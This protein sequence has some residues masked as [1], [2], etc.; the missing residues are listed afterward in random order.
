MR[1]PG[2]PFADIQFLS[3]LIDKLRVTENIDSARVYATGASSGGIFSYR[4]AC[5]LSGKIAAIGSVAGTDV[6]PPCRPK[7]PVSV[8]EIHELGDP[9]EPYAGTSI[10]PSTPA[11]VAK[12]RSVDQCSSASTTTTTPGVKD[13]SWTKCANGTSV[14][15]I[16]VTGSGHG[17]IRTNGVDATTAIWRFFAAHPKVQASA[18]RPSV[19]FTRVRVV[20]RPRRRVLVSLS[21]GQASVVDA[22]LKRGRR[23]VAKRSERAAKGTFVLV[24]NVP[25]SARPGT[26]KLVVVAKA[27]GSSRQ[28]ARDLHLT[29]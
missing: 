8:I 9:I 5:Y 14:E 15:L 2:T 13:Q 24:L 16:S 21:V 25:V 7:D 18:T 12:W 22:S 1:G 27:S 29:R 6:S 17:W 4:A 10:T 19:R 20:Y 11:V 23:V 28:I 3:S 26:Y